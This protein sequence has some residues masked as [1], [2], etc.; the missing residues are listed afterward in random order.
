MF[1][2]F[3][4]M[5]RLLLEKNWFGMSQNSILLPRFT[6][7]VLP[8]HNTKEL[9]KP[10]NSRNYEIRKDHMT[11][12]KENKIINNLINIIKNIIQDSG[13]W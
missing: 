1:S 10:L 2:Q 3:N 7:Q 13:L 9:Q 6:W 12:Q 5:N 11:T 8:P 4:K